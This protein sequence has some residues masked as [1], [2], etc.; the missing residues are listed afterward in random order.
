MAGA[1]CQGSG[2]RWW[3]L[4][5]GGGLPGMA[6]PGPGGLQKPGHM[7]LQ[8]NLPQSLKYR[9]LGLTPGESAFTRSGIKVSNLYL[10]KEC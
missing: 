9:M 1:G 2:D 4:R 8:Q 7:P 6:S 3:A 5:E 10:R